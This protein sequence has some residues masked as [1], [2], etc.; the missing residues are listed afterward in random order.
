MLRLR[1]TTCAVRVAGAM[2]SSSGTRPPTCWPASSAA[3][4]GATSSSRSA[5][6]ERAFSSIVCSAVVTTASS[7]CARFPPAAGPGH[8][9]A[10]GILGPFITAEVRHRQ[11]VA[12]GSPPGADMSAGTT[13]NL[14][15][16]SIVWVDH[17][18]PL[19]DARPQLDG[20]PFPRA[21][22][23]KRLRHARYWKLREPLDLR[24]L[25]GLARLASLLRRL[26]AYSAATTARPPAACCACPIRQP[27]STSAQ[28]G[29]GRADHYDDGGR[30]R[31]RGL[32]AGRSGPPEP[33][34]DPVD[35]SDRQ[36]T[37]QGTTRSPSANATT[38]YTR[39]PARCARGQS[40]DVIDVAI[41]AVNESFARNRS[42]R[43]NLRPAP[44]RAA[45]AEPR[46][47]Q[48]ASATTGRHPRRE[49]ATMNAQ[50]PVPG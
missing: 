45:A 49:G 4:C 38:S 23:A 44:L 25:A 36:S 3:R 50:S 11:D 43:G 32:P 6:G 26:A 40:A 9:W 30:V 24:E 42:R 20:F 37:R 29:H 35:H 41:R 8:S 16:T 13:A 2:R 22:R 31:A 1:R 5:F 33:D 27:Q 12:S 46:G 28:A 14:A 48:A 17:D 10:S 21:D 39:W 18:T 47:L 19:E 15:Q 34:D 7:S